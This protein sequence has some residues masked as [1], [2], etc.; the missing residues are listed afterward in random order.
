MLWLIRTT[1]TPAS[2]VR[3][4]TSRTFSRW[5]TPSA[6]VGSSMNRSLDAQ[7]TARVTATFC[8]SPP[9]RDA[10]RVVTLGSLVPSS[11]NAFAAAVCIAG[12]SIILSHRSGPRRKILSSE[13]Q[14]CCRVEVGSESKVLIY[15]L[16]P[17]ALSLCRGGKPHL[18]AVEDDPSAR[19]LICAAEALH[20]GALARSIVADECDDLAGVNGKVSTPE[21]LYMAE[22]SVEGL[23]LQ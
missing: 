22:R 10:I 1:A 6:A 17:E 20:K 8:R 4:M 7:A 12:L 3:R 14:V 15:R 5:T 11:R 2:R 16:Y 21:S 19:W 13:V 9:D 18:L 23:S